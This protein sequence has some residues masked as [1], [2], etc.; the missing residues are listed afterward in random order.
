MDSGDVAAIIVTRG[1]CD[2]TPILDSLI[3]EE[4]VVWDNSQTRTDEGAYGRYWGIHRTD[5]SIIYF[6]DD[7]CLVSPEDQQ[8]LVD[9]YEPGMLTALMPADRDDY[10]DTVLI[11]WGSIFDWHLPREAFRR[12]RDAGYDITTPEFKIVGADF[13]FP[14]L[15]RWKRLDG[16][17]INLP[18][19]YA[20]NRTWAS[21]PDYARVK[22]MYLSRGRRL[23]DGG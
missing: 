16:E 8:R 22:E 6:Q 14:M 9:A 10:R 7:D 17:H 5:R 11:G 23:R 13:V 12:W 1:D 21:Y 2:I 15:S 3:F 19:A 4:V 20:D 18:H